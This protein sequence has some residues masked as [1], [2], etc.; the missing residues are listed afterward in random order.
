MC[1]LQDKIEIEVSI[2]KKLQATRRKDLLAVLLMRRI[3]REIKNLMEELYA[4]KS[5]GRRQ[6]YQRANSLE[7][8]RYAKEDRT[9]EAPIHARDHR[10]LFGLSLFKRLSGGGAS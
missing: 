8:L 4:T 7:A 10:K 1:L 9:T 2:L 5:V 6:D 3:Q